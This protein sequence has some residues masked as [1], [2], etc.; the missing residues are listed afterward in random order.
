MPFEILL[1]WFRVRAA[2]GNPGYAGSVGS[3]CFEQV[4]TISKTDGEIIDHWA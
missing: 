4:F 1:M 3:I 2:A